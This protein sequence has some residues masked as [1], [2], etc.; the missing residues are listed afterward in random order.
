MSHERY[1]AAATSQVRLEPRRPLERGD[2]SDDEVHIRRN[3]DG[4]GQLKLPKNG[5][6]GS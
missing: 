5:K 6:Q 2:L 3:L 4:T 1:L